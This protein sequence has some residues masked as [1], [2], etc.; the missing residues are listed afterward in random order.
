[1]RLT[2]VQAVEALP[3]ANGH[4]SAALQDT[5]SGSSLPV[6]TLQPS[7]G[8]EPPQPPVTASDLQV[9]GQEGVARVAVH[10]VVIGDGGLLP[11]DAVGELDLQGIYEQAG[12]GSQGLT[13]GSIR[14]PGTAPSV[15][16]HAAPLPSL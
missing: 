9:L 5:L 15:H 13:T 2:E 14:F 6:A 8:P 7:S 11:L 4:S 3:G 10:A 16:M 1:M 12:R